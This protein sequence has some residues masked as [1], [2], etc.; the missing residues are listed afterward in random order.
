LGRWVSCDPIGIGDGLNLYGYVRGN[1]L[2]YGDPSGYGAEEQSLGKKNERASE[3]HQSLA[4]KLRQKKGMNPIKVDYGKGVGGKRE[5]IPD[6]VKMSPK[7]GEP[8]LVVEL[9]ARHLDSKWNELETN[10]EADIINNL[11][12]GKE[13]LKAL[14]KSGE[15]SSDLKS[16][17]VRVIHDSDRGK[18]ATK[19]LDKWRNEA[20]SVREKWVEKAT[21]AEKTLRE[22]VNVVT[23]TRDRLSKAT[24]ALKQSI[25]KIGKPTESPSVI[26]SS[27]KSRATQR[28]AV[29]IPS[30]TSAEKTSLTGLG[31]TTVINLAKQNVP[32]LQETEDLLS[33]F[34]DPYKASTVVAAATYVKVAGTQAI[35]AVG[36]GILSLGSSLTNPF[37]VIGNPFESFAPPVPNKS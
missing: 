14:E 32:L 5:I 15:G 24:T 9:K 17:V 28:G 6:E 33:N 4:N 20:K 25:A 16:K 10:R 23:T 36:A 27:T 29:I 35:V 8:K 22:R 1:P 30:L 3:L 31:K 19:A 37:V 12:Q 11:E 13:Q 18:S 7:S 2:L 26:R 34:G 21:G